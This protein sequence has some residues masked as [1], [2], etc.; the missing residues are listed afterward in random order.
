[1]N[2]NIVAIG[3]ADLG[4]PTFT[5]VAGIDGGTDITNIDPGETVA[6]IES[7]GDYMAITGNLVTRVDNDDCWEAAGAQPTAG[8]T[9]TVVGS[10][11]RIPDYQRGLTLVVDVDGVAHFPNAGHLAAAITAG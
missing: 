8:D 5:A 2:H 4:S 9:I 1:M 11:G 3:Y 6:V 7:V 10:V